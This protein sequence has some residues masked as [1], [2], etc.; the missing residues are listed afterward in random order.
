[1]RGGLRNTLLGPEATGVWSVLVSGDV[2]SWCW[3]G[4]GVVVLVSLSLD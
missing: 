1:M 2:G 3:C 4:V